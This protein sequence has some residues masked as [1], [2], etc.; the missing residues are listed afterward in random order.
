MTLIKKD[1]STG[2]YYFVLDAGRDLLSGKRTQFRRRGFETKKEA[3]VALAKL[4]V[5]ISEEKEISLSRLHFHKYLERWFN[6]KKIKLKTSTIQNYEQ[7]IRYNIAPYI[8]DVRMD[9]FNESIIQ[10]YVQTLH[11]E[12]KLSPATI[13]TR[14]WHRSRSAL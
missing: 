10:N 6:A 14:L 9:E 8:G 4:Q 1:L 11:K 3:Q 2:K 13:R 7:Q 12:R 5:Q